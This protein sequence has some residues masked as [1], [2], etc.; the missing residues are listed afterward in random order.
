[1]RRLEGSETMAAKLAFERKMKQ[2]GVRLQKYRADNGRFSDNSFR[3]HCEDN[4]QE[5][6]F[7]AVGDHHQN[8]IV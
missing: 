7:C 8:G 5:I 1:M 4:G 6:K 2:H 3:K